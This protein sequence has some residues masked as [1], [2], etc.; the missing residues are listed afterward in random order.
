MTYHC[1]SE[2]YAAEMYRLIPLKHI[3][4]H[5]NKHKKTDNLKTGR[6]PHVT[7]RSKVSY[8]WYVKLYLNAYLLCVC[9]C[10]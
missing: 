4:M 7:D 5:T 3:S 2:T 6:K 1:L 10:K 9:H 8:F